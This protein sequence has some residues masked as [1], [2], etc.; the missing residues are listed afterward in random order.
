MR[1]DADFS[2]QKHPE[3]ERSFQIY[4]T[5]FGD[6][7]HV[8]DYEL[9]DKEEDTEL[10]EKTVHNLV[11][12]LNDTPDKLE[13]VS[14]LANMRLYFNRQEPDEDTGWSRMLLKTHPPGRAMTENTLITY[15]PEFINP[16]ILSRL[17]GTRDGGS[18]MRMP[19]ADSHT[20]IAPNFD[21]TFEGG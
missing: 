1:E 9:I 11:A 5:E 17:C 13:D 4:C 12:L 6:T 18:G 2:Y 21:P 10:T 16:A 20:S 7:F 8:G 3:K 19:K 14:E 15:D